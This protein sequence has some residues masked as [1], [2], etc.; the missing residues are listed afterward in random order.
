MSLSVG[1]S[2]RFHFHMR[3]KF[4]TQNR[5]EFEIFVGVIYSRNSD[6][7]RDEEKDFLF[8]CF[9]VTRFLFREFRKN[10][11]NIEPT[12]IIS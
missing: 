9:K 12:T 5:L 10:T 4:I 2:R 8:K 11:Y 1:V 6:R 3:V 7:E